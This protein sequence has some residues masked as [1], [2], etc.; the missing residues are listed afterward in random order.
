MEG[1]WE[2]QQTPDSRRKGHMQHTDSAAAYWV[3]C[4]DQLMLVCSCSPA[5]EWPTSLHQRNVLI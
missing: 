1:P 3:Q 4:R 5:A 2:R